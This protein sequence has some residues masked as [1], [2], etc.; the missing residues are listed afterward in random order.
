MTKQFQQFLTMLAGIVILALDWY[1]LH[2]AFIFIFGAT[3]V[4][5][6]IALAI[7]LFGVYLMFRSNQE[8]LLLKHKPTPTAVLLT[9]GYH[10][11]ALA[12]L[13]AAAHF[14]AA[15]LFIVVIVMAWVLM[16]IIRAVDNELG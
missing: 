13:I 2:P 1:T 15:S 10:I 7:A 12:Y 11:A 9:A 5:T 14:V 4:F 3:S 6:I 8:H 16:S